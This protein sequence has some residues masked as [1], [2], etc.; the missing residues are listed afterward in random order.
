MAKKTAP[1]P[2]APASR[3]RRRRLGGRCPLEAQGCQED[4]SQG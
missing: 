2:A 1:A 3:P 4:C